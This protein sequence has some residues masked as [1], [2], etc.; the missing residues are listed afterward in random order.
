MTEYR[1]IARAIEEA[2]AHPSIPA[3][4]AYR[5]IGGALSLAG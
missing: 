4:S 3:L 1:P 5:S 2:L